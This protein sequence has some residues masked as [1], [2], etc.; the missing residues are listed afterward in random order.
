MLILLLLGY[1]DLIEDL[2]ISM[3]KDYKKTISELQQYLTVDEISGIL[4]SPDFRTANQAIIKCL[5]TRMT[6]GH[7]LMTFCDILESITDAPAL[8]VAIKHL[9]QC[10][11]QYVTLLDLI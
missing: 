7:Q 1:F 2:M 6:T 8:A 4:E 10:R 3:P 5:M 11:S 9:K